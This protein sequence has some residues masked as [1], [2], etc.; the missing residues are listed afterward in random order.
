MRFSLIL[1]GFF[2]LSSFL[3]GKIIVSTAYAEENLVLNGDFSEGF[4]HWGIMVY[5]VGNAPTVSVAEVFLGNPSLSMDVP[6]GSAAMVYQYLDL[7]PTE[8][9]KDRAILSFKVFG[10]RDPVYA[11][12]YLDFL[13]GSIKTLEEFDPLGKLSFEGVPTFKTYDITKYCNRTLALV[14]FATSPFTMSPTL[15]IDDVKVVVTTG[16]NSVITSSAQP[17]ERGSFPISTGEKIV[18]NGSISPVPSETTN[19]TLTFVPPLGTPIIKNVM[20]NSS[21]EY[22]FEF[23]P[24]M[25]G[26][27]KV[28][29]FWPGDDQYDNA[30]S[31]YSQFIVSANSGIFA[32]R[33]VIN[34][35]E[36]DLGSPMLEVLPGENLTGFLEF[37]TVGTGRWENIPVVAISSHEKIRWDLLAF[38]LGIVRDYYGT[39]LSPFGHK[40]IIEPPQLVT[41]VSPD[42]FE[43]AFVHPFRW[44]FPVAPEFPNDLL[45][46]ELTLVAEHPKYIAPTEENTTFHIVILQD[47]TFQARDIIFPPSKQFLDR[48]V[49]SVW[50]LNSTEWKRFELGKRN[51]T[52]A[53][54]SNILA[55][56]I[57]VVAD[58]SPLID[59]AEE[60]INEVD[61]N[62]Y[63]FPEFSIAI[64]EAKDMLKEAETSFANR[65][66]SE[67]GELAVNASEAA[68]SVYMDMKKDVENSAGV[69]FEQVTELGKLMD[70]SD[71]L[72]LMDRIEGEI[73]G[74]NLARAREF[75]FE[76]YTTIGGY[77]F[78]TGI[79]VYKD[80]VA[81]GNNKMEF[82]ELKTRIEAV[83]ALFMEAQIAFDEREFSLANHLVENVSREAQIILGYIKGNVSQTLLSSN[84]TLSKEKGSVWNAVVDF[85]YLENILQDATKE[86]NAE[87]YATA[88]RLLREFG[89]EMDRFFMARE[90]LVTMI[91]VGL[92]F[93]GVYAL[94]SLE[95]KKAKDYVLRFIFALLTATIIYLV[96]QAI[97][98][99]PLLV[100]S[101]VLPYSIM[102][103]VI[104]F[105]ERKKPRTKPVALVFCIVMLVLITLLFVAKIYG[106]W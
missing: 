6:I 95:E 93:S 100:L 80:V 58:P 24:N 56:P 96:F 71:L 70:I 86:Y 89:R 47:A 29:S 94:L 84:E 14:F 8:E 12:I 78:P 79:S 49:D 77:S 74:G 50:D 38:H 10:G 60:I 26:I 36:V 92:F 81:L 3:S 23:S 7:P 30:T 41:Y 39:Q 97:R 5:Q 101:I 22:A 69:L 55:I 19:V 57:K 88:R 63:A 105:L 34:G 4:A 99:R 20:T 18:V 25:T 59:H 21:G 51:E 61:Q 44:E 106:L 42:P 85:T 48:T 52:D 73:S 45:G 90:I 102:L 16:R 65:R 75:T 17:S 13:N 35:V 67:S 76:L 46:D 66:F 31:S 62:I 11:W 40:P 43:G 91:V 32:S 54:A 9:E 15:N 87:D 82:P 68:N 103:A 64:D 33:C 83:E 104:A 53:V 27:W 28:R 1:L 98:W 72:I 2:L 37:E